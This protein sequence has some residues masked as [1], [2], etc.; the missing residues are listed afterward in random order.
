MRTRA[1]VKLRAGRDLI[2]ILEFPHRKINCS[3]AVAAKLFSYGGIVGTVLCRGGGL[4][5]YSRARFFQ[6]INS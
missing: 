4:N 3:A 1:S 5:F 2:M 6:L